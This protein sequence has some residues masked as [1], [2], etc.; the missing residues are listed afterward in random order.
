MVKARRDTRSLDCSSNVL[1]TVTGQ[2]T[3]GE[4]YAGVLAVAPPN[5]RTEP[6]TLNMIHAHQNPQTITDH[7]PITPFKQVL[8]IEFCGLLWYAFGFTVSGLRV[9]GLRD[10]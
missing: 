7:N 5:N 6:K 1:S 8:S 4:A 10:V 2:H 9:L 3:L